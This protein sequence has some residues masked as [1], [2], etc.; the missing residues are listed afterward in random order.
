[1]LRVDKNP[2][3]VISMIARH[4]Q[5]VADLVDTSNK[6]ERRAEAAERKASELSLIH[7]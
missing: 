2:P 1:M 7:I 6:L 4:R 5:Q 3:H